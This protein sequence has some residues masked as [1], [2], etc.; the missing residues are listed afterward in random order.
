[1][2][3]STLTLIILLLYIG[4]GFSSDADLMSDFLHLKNFGRYGKN[5]LGC[6]YSVNNLNARIYFNSASCPFHDMHSHEFACFIQDQRKVNHIIH[7][8][9]GKMVD[10]KRQLPRL[11]NQTI[12]FVGDSL[13]ANQFVSLACLLWEADIAITEKDLFFRG[14]EHQRLKLHKHVG[15]HRVGHS[16]RTVSIRSNTYNL[17]VQFLFTGLLLN[18]HGTM[19]GRINNITIAKEV[20]D[21]EWQALLEGRFEPLI[22]TPSIIMLSAGHHFDKGKYMGENAPTV[23]RHGGIYGYIS[24]LLGGRK[25]HKNNQ[26]NA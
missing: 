8:T 3:Y 14:N 4:K 2:G 15:E 5:F 13:V 11:A 26:F 6:V 21:F 16:I 17:E 23:K 1:M 10:L 7:S 22:K 12:L 19:L 24:E 9:P 20:L 25:K 18:A